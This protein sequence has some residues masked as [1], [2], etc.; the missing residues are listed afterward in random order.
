MLLPGESHGLRSLGAAVH[1]VAES[2]T[3]ERL[4]F[5]GHLKPVGSAVIS[6][7]VLLM[8][9]TYDH[10]FLFDH[11]FLLSTCFA[12]NLLSFLKL[13]EVNSS[14]FLGNFFLM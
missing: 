8:L 13:P 2:D 12:F 1:R 7:P 6:S 10:R 3:P 14:I 5:S 9:V 11:Y 4:H